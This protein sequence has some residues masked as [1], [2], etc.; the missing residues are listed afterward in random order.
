MHIKL[1]KWWI[2]VYC[3]QK[4]G[5]FGLKLIFYWLTKMLLI[6]GKYEGLF[7]NRKPRISA[8]HKVKNNHSVYIQWIFLVS[9]WSFGVNYPI[10][11]VLLTHSPLIWEKPQNFI[12]F[13]VNKWSQLLLLLFFFFNYRVCS[14]V[15]NQEWKKY[16]CTISIYDFWCNFNLS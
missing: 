1:Y 3:F 7:V 14:D 10:I 16:F 2:F 8:R 12:E 15:R 4:G 6:W 13:Y 9:E 11:C 5:Y